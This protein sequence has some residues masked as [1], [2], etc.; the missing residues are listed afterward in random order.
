MKYSD[1][2]QIRLRAL[3]PE[4]LDLLYS[5][6]NNMA[7]WNVGITNV[8]YSRYALHDYIA[9]NSGDIYADK[10]VRMMAENEEGEVVGVLDLT[11]FDPTHLRSEIGILVI[12]A[13]CGKG[14]G[15]AILSQ[16]AFYAQH[17]L[18][19]HQLYAYVDV[20]NEKSIKLF[21]SM[22]Y[23][24]SSCLVDWLYDGTSYRDAIVLQCF[25]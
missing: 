2:P 21:T 20:T 9:T 14:Y 17:I 4:D 10:Q 16:A 25:F 22:G 7:L 3:E 13:F 11:N 6:E 15:K 19:L 1:Y 24:K 8:P 12:D 23:R 18:H 5:I